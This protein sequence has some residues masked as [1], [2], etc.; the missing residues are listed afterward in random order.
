VSVRAAPRRASESLNI[1]LPVDS[2]PALIHTTRPDG[3][4]VYFNNPLGRRRR[5][6]FGSELRLDVRFVL[7]TSTVAFSCRWLNA[8][9]CWSKLS[10]LARFGRASGHR[11]RVLAA[12]FARVES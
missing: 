11:S 10:T 8:A 3:Y 6:I 7:R 9:A 4:F 1:Q 12:I 2:I 5:Q